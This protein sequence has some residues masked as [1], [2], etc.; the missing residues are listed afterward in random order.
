MKNNKKPIMIVNM[1]RNSL[2]CV[3]QHHPLRI[4]QENKNKERPHAAF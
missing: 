1:M 4:D 3:N 2:A